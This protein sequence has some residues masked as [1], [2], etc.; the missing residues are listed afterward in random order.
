MRQNQIKF[1]MPG[2]KA[3]VGQE[4]LSPSFINDGIITSISLRMSEPFSLKPEHQSEPPILESVLD[5]NLPKQDIESLI[6]P[7]ATMYMKQT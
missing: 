3:V 1:E 5:F 4:I 6:K 7:I 2:F